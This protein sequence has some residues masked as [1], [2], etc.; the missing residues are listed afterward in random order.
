[1]AA[2]SALR[3]MVRP[4]DASRKILPASIITAP[5]ARVSRANIERLPI[6]SIHTSAQS[7]A[8]YRRFG[9]RPSEGSP[10]GY[11][12]PYQPRN[13]QS[14]ETPL[15]K[16]LA[17]QQG[18]NNSRRRKGGFDPFSRVGISAIVLVGGG[19]FY[20]THLER[21]PDTGRWRFM[22]VSL[23]Q[24]RQTAD[25]AF[26][27]VLKEFQGKILRSSDPIHQYVQGVASRIIRAASVQRQEGNISANHLSDSLHTGLHHPSDPHERKQDVKWQVFVV[28]DDTPNAFVLPNGKIFVNT[29]IL[30]ICKDEDGLATVL[31]HE[32]AHQLVRH[33]A[34][35][36]SSS[37]LYIILG[38]AVETL[39]GINFGISSSALQILI[40][41]PNS[42]ACET[43]ADHIGLRL[44]SSAC[45]DPTKAPSLWERMQKAEKS[46]ADSSRFTEILSTHPTS[47]KREKQM[48][49]WLP[50]ADRIRQNSNCPNPT[51]VSSFKESIPYLSRAY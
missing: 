4:S 24:E 27:Q 25:Q 1:M 21:V 50:E 28:K 8:N 6:Q 49:Q 7:N 5:F 10:S 51:T 40:G 20:V 19:I 29:G 38:F 15:W 3:F 26:N 22:Y 16:R 31:G 17:I 11:P 23:E 18:Q 35:K 32:V 12:S 39:L 44:M 48:K 2:R 14:Q 43:E 33:G 47:V 42:R 36:M 45:F 41:L 34:E 9:D 13:G 46:L 30:P 37:Y